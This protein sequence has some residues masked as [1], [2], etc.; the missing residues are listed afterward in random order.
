MRAV[1]KSFCSCS[2]SWACWPIWR[3]SSWACFV[4]GLLLGQGF[5]AA[6]GGGQLHAQLS[7]QGFCPVGPLAL[8]LGGVGLALLDCLAARCAEGFQLLERSRERH[9]GP[10]NVCG[11]GVDLARCQ[12]L[13]LHPGLHLDNRP[14]PAPCLPGA[15]VPAKP[16]GVGGRLD[17]GGPAG[18]TQ[19]PDG[20][21]LDCL[22]GG[23]AGAQH[24][25]QQA[26]YRLHEQHPLAWV[27][28]CAERCQ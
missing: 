25:R 4:P 9:A 14:S 18:E 23:S 13:G 21:A 2:I 19:L 26:G 17:H 22:G 12:G 28:L 8:C 20:A 11:D 5:G 15:D 24:V 16:P 27:G 3:A 10:L 7:G 1:A 6:R